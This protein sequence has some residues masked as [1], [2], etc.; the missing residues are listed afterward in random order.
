MA[1]GRKQQGW[2]NSQ[3]ALQE[4]WCR[5]FICHQSTQEGGGEVLQ[6]LERSEEQS[7]ACVSTEEVLPSNGQKSLQA[8]ITNWAGAEEGHPPECPAAGP[9]EDLWVAPQAAV[10]SGGW[11][12]KNKE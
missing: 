6:G 3:K 4:V 10:Y 5:L 2:H 1:K 9:I 8:L 7:R 11:E 12:A